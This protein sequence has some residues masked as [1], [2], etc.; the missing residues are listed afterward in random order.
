MQYE[1]PWV[2]TRLRIVLWGLLCDAHQST[3]GYVNATVNLVR[4]WLTPS[5]GAS[6]AVTSVSMTLSETMVLGPC[7]SD[8]GLKDPCFTH[9]MGLA[10]FV[11]LLPR[12]QS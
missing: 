7:C 3:S 4:G 11:F 9:L 2:R 6:C 1:L 12:P 10:Q 8:Q 5:Q